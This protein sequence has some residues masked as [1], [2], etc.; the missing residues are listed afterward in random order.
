MDFPYTV[1]ADKTK[2]KTL[3]I[4]LFVP[5]HRPLIAKYNQILNLG[6]GDEKNSLFRSLSPIFSLS[7]HHHT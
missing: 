1:K 5:K 2:F 4:Y 7:L 6:L 3:Q